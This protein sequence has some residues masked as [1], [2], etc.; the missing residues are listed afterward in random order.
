MGCWCCRLLTHISV[1]RLLREVIQT[2]LS[3]SCIC[4]P[5]CQSANIARQHCV[6]CSTDGSVVR[7]RPRRGHDSQTAGGALHAFRRGPGLR[8]RASESAQQRGGSTPRPL[9]G[10]RLCQPGAEGRRGAATVP[11]HGEDPRVELCSHMHAP[12]NRVLIGS[13]HVCG[14]YWADGR[15]QTAAH[16]CS[17]PPLVYGRAAGPA[18]AA[19]CRHIRTAIRIIDCAS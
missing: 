8:C 16:S 3:M 2:I 14:G 18:P 7:R 5:T 4:C 9:P 1:L 15:C 12:S 13:R 11:Q 6:I 17:P 10:L 19:M